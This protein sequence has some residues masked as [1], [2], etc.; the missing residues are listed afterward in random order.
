M[1]VIFRRPSGAHDFVE[2]VPVAALRLPP[3]N[4]RQ[5]SGLR[6]CGFI[7]GLSRFSGQVGAGQAE[8]SYV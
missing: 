6:L 1:N 8:Q 5:P 7:L 4:I 2:S 3:A